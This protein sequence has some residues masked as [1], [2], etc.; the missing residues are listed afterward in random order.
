MF[1][2]ICSYVSYIA[3]LIK[4]IMAKKET[5]HL[6]EN[7]ENSNMKNVYNWHVIET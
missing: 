6:Y 7:N 3:L 1:R 4:G 2:T 5:I